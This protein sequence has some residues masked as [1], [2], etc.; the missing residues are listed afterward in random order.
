LGLDGINIDFEPL[1]PVEGAYF[2]QFLRELAQRLGM[3][4][5]VLSVNVAPH[6]TAFYS[7]ELLGMAVDYIMV[8]ALDEHGHDAD[9]SGPVASLP[10]VQAGIDNLLAH[11]PSGQLVLGVPFYNR[12]WREIIG[13]NTPETRRELHFGTAYTREWFEY[14]GV[15]WEWLPEIGSYYGGFVALEGDETAHYRVWLECGRSMDAKLQIV[16]GSGLAGSA[17]W[18]RNFRNNDELWDVIGQHFGN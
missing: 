16:T 13:N 15:T 12:V 1:S 3:S 11:I 17:V 8:M 5:A 9:I 14:N 6:G 10:F 4:N 7:R 2:I 18:N